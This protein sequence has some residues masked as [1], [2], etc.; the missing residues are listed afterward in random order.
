MRA[1][2]W[3]FRAALFVVALGFALSNT[4][5]AELR[6]FGFDVAW[7]APLVV[8]LL[9]FFAAGAGLGLLGVVPALFR[10]RRELARLRRELKA[11]AGKAGSAPA[12]QPPLP[13][14]P[15]PVPGAADGPASP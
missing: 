2:T 14:A 8:F 10:Q 6:F 13:D 15:R 4:G 9:V 7:R 3:L 5:V 1:L 11:V 12:A